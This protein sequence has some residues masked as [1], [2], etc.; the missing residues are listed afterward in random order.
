[1]G[2]QDNQNNPI[3]SAP[4]SEAPPYPQVQ[5]ENQLPLQTGANG[6]ETNPD[7]PPYQETFNYPQAPPY[8]VYAPT[9]TMPTSVQPPMPMPTQP[10]PHYVYPPAPAPQIIYN[11]NPQPPP[12]PTTNTHTSTNVTVVTATGPLRVD[13]C[14]ACMGSF[15]NYTDCCYL[16][17]LIIIAICTLPF[18]L[19]LV[20]FFFCACRKRCNGCGRPK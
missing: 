3:P 20:P 6:R 18:G 7:P 4:P 19:L 13:P 17:I 2:K 1:M 5:R 15:V 16:T 11:V 9:T 14:P 12:Q 10:P 8:P